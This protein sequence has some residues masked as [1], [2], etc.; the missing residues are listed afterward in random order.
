MQTRQTSKRLGGWIAAAA[1][2][3]AASNGATAAVISGSASF[4]AWGFGAGAPADPVNGTVSWSF[5]N[6]ANIFN[7]ADGTVANGVAVHVEILGVSLP[8][9][10]TP[11]LT[12]FKNAVVN[13]VPFVDVLAIGHS[14]N[15]TLVLPA[16]NDWRIAFSDASGD[17]GFRE[18]TYATSEKSGLFMSTTGVVPEPASL[19][20]LAAGLLAAG[21]LKRRRGT[22]AMGA[23]VSTKA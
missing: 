18:L 15:G 17:L 9:S 10:W 6:S 20:V 7:A 1:M 22:A 8:G 5:D 4:N 14:L 16:T 23:G 19:G 3:L 21:A 11:V 12:Y 2:A 13:G